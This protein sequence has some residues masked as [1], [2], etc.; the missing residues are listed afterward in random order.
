MFKLVKLRSVIRIPPSMFGSDLQSIATTVLKE[1]YQ[2]KLF[3]D[4]GLVVAVFDPQVSDEG[5]IIPGD[6]ATYHEVTFNALT[7]YPVQGEVVEGIVTQVTQNLVFINIGPLDGVVHV[8]QVT[9]DRLKFDPNRGALI[10]ET[11]KKVLQK[12]DVVRARVIGVSIEPG[13]GMR[14]QMTM[15][16]PYLGKLEW[17]TPGK[18]KA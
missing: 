1:A 10:G 3:K 8:S 9:D 4:I 14:V 13:R 7:F 17:I 12:G 5:M 6:G 18:V 2:D 11:S 15:R 16:Q